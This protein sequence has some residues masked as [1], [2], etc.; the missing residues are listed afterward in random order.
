MTHLS[1]LGST[2][3][4]GMDVESVTRELKSRSSASTRRSQA[5]EASSGSD[6]RSAQSEDTENERRHVTT[7]SESS[8]ASSL[9]LMRPSSLERTPTDTNASTSS[10]GGG[11]RDSAAVDD[12]S[13]LSASVTSTSARSWVDEFSSQVSGSNA[14]VTAEFRAEEGLQLSMPGPSSSTSLVSPVSNGDG[15]DGRL[16]ESLTSDSMASTSGN[17]RVRMSLVIWPSTSSQLRAS[18]LHFRRVQKAVGSKLQV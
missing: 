9:E 3:I 18:A 10:R 7:P 6:D 17:E 16:T 15:G 12:V 1:T 5:L 8:L 11:S 4:S 13:L 14:G 2:V